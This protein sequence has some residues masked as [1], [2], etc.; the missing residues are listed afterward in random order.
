[1]ADEAA[2]AGNDDLF[3]SNI[4]CH[5]YNTRTE[6]PF[7][8]TSLTQKSKATPSPQRNAIER[9]RINRIKLEG[10]VSYAIVSQDGAKPA[11]HD[12]IRNAP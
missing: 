6:S 11:T 2:T 10:K 7:P 3:A 12:I 1:M 5:G 8:L 9:P 4:S